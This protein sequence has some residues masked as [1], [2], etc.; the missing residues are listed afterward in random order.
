MTIRCA[1]HTDADAIMGI[2][3]HY[4]THTVAT[5]NSQEKTKTEIETLISNQPVFVAQYDETIT[6]FATYG[7]FRK[8]VGYAKTAEHSLFLQNG[9]KGQGRRLMNHIEVDAKSNGVH[10]MFA[11][12][13]AENENAIGFHQAIGYEHVAKLNQV[14]W[15]F[16]RWHDLIL[17]Q[18]FL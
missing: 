17:M 2:W 1:I 12:I 13:S 6:G 10:S 4:I 7:D 11:G 15:K 5:F 3:N 18:K 14:G 16:D 9:K 8:G